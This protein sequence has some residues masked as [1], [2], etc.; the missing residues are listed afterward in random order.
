MNA[1]VAVVLQQSY[2]KLV[3]N[4]QVKNPR[5]TSFLST[6][7]ENCSP[8]VRHKGERETSNAA[9]NQRLQIQRLFSPFIYRH[10]KADGYR[11]LKEFELKGVVVNP[12]QLW[13]FAVYE[14]ETEVT[15]MQSHRANFHSPAV[16]AVVAAAACNSLSTLPIELEL[17]DCLYIVIVDVDKGHLRKFYADHLGG[18]SKKGKI[19]SNENRRA[20]MTRLMDVS[21]AREIRKDR[22]MW[23]SI[24]SAFLPLLGHKRSSHGSSEIYATVDCIVE[25]IHE[26]DIGVLLKGAPILR[27]PST[28]R[29]KFAWCGRAWEPRTSMLRARFKH[30]VRVLTVVGFLVNVM[31]CFPIP[32]T[33][34]K[35]RKHLL[36]PE[37]WKRNLAKTVRWLCGPK[38]EQYVIGDVF[39]VANG[40]TKTRAL[41][42]DMNPKEIPAGNNVSSCKAVDVR[43]LLIAH[44]GDE[45]QNIAKLN[46]FV[47]LLSNIQVADNDEQ[48]EPETQDISNIICEPQEENDELIV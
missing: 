43:K 40:S 41:S 42:S 39:K 23:K 21:E 9:V 27:V 36:Q 12:K 6:S 35:S 10:R 19:L 48:C 33:D 45:W 31:E 8:S 32:V 47:P 15:S 14:R 25:K 13:E 44:Y 26:A 22:I 3:L 37:K 17:C 20:C 29:I 46:F 11:K 1:S 24:G 16:S 4:V 38:Q 18:I 5:Y 2:M 28:L 30:L 34:N 7:Q